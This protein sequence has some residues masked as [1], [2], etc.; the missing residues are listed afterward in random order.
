MGANHPLNRSRAKRSRFDWLCRGDGVGPAPERYELPQLCV[1]GAATHCYGS[2]AVGTI[3]DNLHVIAVPK[4]DT[5]KGRIE[6]FV[7]SVHLILRSFA[8]QSLLI[9]INRP[10]RKGELQKV[11]VVL[12]TEAH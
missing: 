5:A 3:F 10:H 2:K 1:D 12:E 7:R 4:S 9:A 6:Q 11:Y 8:N